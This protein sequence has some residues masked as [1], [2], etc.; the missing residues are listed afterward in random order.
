VKKPETPPASFDM[1]DRDRLTRLADFL[2]EVGMLRKTPRTGYQF[3]GSGAEN[4]A[5]HSFRTAVIGF[6]LAEMRGADPLRTM[7]LCLCHDLHVPHRRFQL[8]QQA[9]QHL[10]CKRALT[11][12]LTGTGLREK[13]LDTWEEL[14]TAGPKRPFWPTA[15]TSWT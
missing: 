10:D 5:E 2:F 14:E 7:A 15:R 6:V 3:L 8:R 1:A 13:L 4:V 9:L 12:A 11:D